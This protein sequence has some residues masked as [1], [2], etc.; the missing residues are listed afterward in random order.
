VEHRI[1]YLHSRIG[2]VSQARIET[3]LLFIHYA[4]IGASVY[5]L[6][7]KVAIRSE[8]HMRMGSIRLLRSSQMLS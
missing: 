5:G 6:I 4:L 8:E 2:K 1:E 7:V 3:G